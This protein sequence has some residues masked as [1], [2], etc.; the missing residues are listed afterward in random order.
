MNKFEALK[1]AKDGLDSWPDLVRY[2]S[3]GTT[4]AEI[5]EDDLQRM[6]WYGVFYRPQKPGT[7]MMRL[8]V[9]GGRMTSAQLRTVADL[10]AEFGGG[11]AD[12]TTR[13]NLQL[14]DIALADVPEIIRRVEACGLGTLQTGLDNVR[15][16]MGCPLA[17]ID[18][19][20]LMD[21]TPLLGAV[22]SAH[23]GKKNFSNLPRKFNLALAGC[24]EDCGHAETQDLGFVPATRRVDGRLVAGFNAL[25]GGALGGSSPRLATPLDVF[26]QPHEVVCL[27]TALLAVYRDHGPREVRTKSRLKWLIAEWGE[28]RLR[29]EV[30]R[31]AGYTFERAGRDERTSTGGDHLGVRPQRQVGLSYAGLHVP[32]GRVTAAQLSGVAALAEAYGAGE[33]RLTTGQNIIIPHVADERVAALLREPLL[34]ELRHDPAPV[35]RGLIACTGN[36]YCHFSLIDT[37]A[38]AIDLATELERRGVTVEPGTRIHLSGCVHA[39]GKHHVADIGLQGANVRL[40]DTVV[41][42]ADIF[43]GGKLGEGARLAVKTGERVVA[44]DL[45]DVFERIL[46]ERS[47]STSRELVGAAL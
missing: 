43:V 30:E 40:G 24:R 7:F 3:E 12:L 5:P 46:G 23:L 9:H 47:G 19:Q 44:E 28:E 31:Y 33:V 2:A 16:Y 25:V 32:V 1:A 17:G 36:D 42:A 18:G 21:T 4:I 15:N 13:Q 8:R 34:Q 29:D 37:K 11:S 20:E 39:C 38:R 27:F 35:W 14:R 26:V 22:A 6:K 41:E 45:P 10:A